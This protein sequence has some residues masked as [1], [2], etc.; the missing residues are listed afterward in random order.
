[1]FCCSSH[2]QAV[3]SYRLWTL[4]RL[5][6]QNV[7][8]LQEVI[9]DLRFCFFIITLVTWERKTKH[10]QQIPWLALI[11]FGQLVFYASFAKP[12]IDLS[13]PVWLFLAFLKASVITQQKGQIMSKQTG[14]L[15]WVTAKRQC[16]A[17]ERKKKNHSLKKFIKSRK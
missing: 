12:N 16:E 10:F 2:F 14:M 3:S 5:P 17:T 1:M 6:L 13:V 15:L 8:F 11:F 7:T 4:I 9:R